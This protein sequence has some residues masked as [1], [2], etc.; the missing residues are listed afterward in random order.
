LLGGASLAVTSVGIYFYLKSRKKIE[1]LEKS[2]SLIQNKPTKTP[3]LLSISQ[4][5]SFLDTKNDDIEPVLAE[6]IRQFEVSKVDTQPTTSSS[7]QPTQAELDQKYEREYADWLAKK[8]AWD[9]KEEQRVREINNQREAEYQRQVAEIE[10]QKQLELNRQRQAE[11]DRQKAILD[12]QRQD[13]LNRQRQAE[14]ERRQ[15]ADFDKRQK[16]IELDRQR[17]ASA[18]QPTRQT[19]SQNQVPTTSSGDGQAVP[20]PSGNRS[21]GNI[22]LLDY[23][24][25]PSTPLVP[26]TRKYKDYGDLTIYLKRAPALGLAQNPQ[27]NAKQIAALLGS[28]AN[29]YNPTDAEVTKLA[30]VLSR[31]RS[32]GADLGQGRMSPINVQRERA[33][34]LW[35]IINAIPAYIKHYGYSKAP[36]TIDEVLAR[37]TEYLNY[38][39]NPRMSDFNEMND[40]LRPDNRNLDPLDFRTFVR[41][42][43]DGQF[44]NEIG[45][46][47]NWVHSKVKK[48]SFFVIPPDAKFSNGQTVKSK[49]KTSY[50]CTSSEDVFIFLPNGIFGRAF[51]KP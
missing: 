9:V 50:G 17:Q 41:A 5:K 31:E 28:N 25:D 46:S 29:K 19:S 18:S 27:Q 24:V 2:S 34:I 20:N 49:C 12:R 6:P 51:V 30:Y 10:R 42:F 21:Y 35:S 45:N 36:H 32:S 1:G 40:Q 13:E 44:N 16:Q 23:V 26:M 3:K 7:K 47:T 4:V 37:G 48:W 8:Q 43:F 14:I 38:A 39:E 15:Q 22:T 11:L 33:A